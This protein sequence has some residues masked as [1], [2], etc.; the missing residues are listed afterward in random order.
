VRVGKG[1]W[2]PIKSISRRTFIFTAPIAGVGLAS[3]VRAQGTA[4]VRE[5]APLFQDVRIFDGRSLALS[6][7]SNVLV[8][9]NLIERISTRPIAVDTIDNVRVIEAGG[10]GLS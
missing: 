8:R 9:G 2:M 1:A 4:P 6:A 7:P 10:R 3:A 5:A